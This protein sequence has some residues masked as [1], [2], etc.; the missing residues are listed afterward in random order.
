M[1]QV[2]TALMQ[3]E[4][5]EKELTKTRSASTRS[6]KLPGALECEILLLGIVSHD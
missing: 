1:L 2:G 3:T 4:S 6:L 5:P